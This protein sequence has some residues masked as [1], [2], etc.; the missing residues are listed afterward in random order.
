MSTLDKPA[1]WNSAAQIS[2]VEIFSDELNDSGK[3]TSLTDVREHLDKMIKTGMSPA[4]AINQDF[5]ILWLFLAQMVRRLAVSMGIQLYS[6]GPIDI[7]THI[8][9]K[10]AD[11]G[12]DNISRFG[13][14][15]LLVRVH[16]KVARL[17]NLTKRGVEPQ[18]ESL[19][20]N[21]TDVIG[22]A[23]IGMMLERDWFKLEL[24]RSQ[25]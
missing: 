9:R 10:Q 6:S 25:L 8:C 22:Y 20:D 21:Y 23:A 5:A 16:D 24:D 11:Y 7:A 15:G 18:N 17:E 3:T 13:R 19:V 4:G 12:H 2:I 1:T 14:I